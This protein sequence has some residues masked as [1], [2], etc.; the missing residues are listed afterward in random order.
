MQKIISL[1][2]RD[3]EGTRFVYD[4]IVP[5]AEWVVNDEGVATVKFDGTCCMIRDLKLYKRY[6]AKVEPTAP[7]TD[8]RTLPKLKNGSKP[9]PEGFIPAQ[10]PDPV[11]GHWPGWLPVR[12]VP[13]DKWHRQ[14]WDKMLRAFG[15][16]IPDGT[17]ELVGPKVQGNPYGYEDHIL[18]RHGMVLLEDAPRTFDE[19]KEYLGKADIE[20]IVWHHPDGRMVKIKR[21][22]FGYKWPLNR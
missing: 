6:D 7:N 18:I 15:A 14:A 8:G 9:I 1:F 13:E 16:N 5:G 19:L 2:K 22:D 4:E 21:R 3:Y 17:C 12:D 20:G 10:D 11:T